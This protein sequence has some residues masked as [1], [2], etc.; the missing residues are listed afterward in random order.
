[1]LGHVAR[2]ECAHGLNIAVV[3][4]GSRVCGKPRIDLG[5]E[6]ACHP[7]RMTG[8]FARGE[9]GSEGYPAADLARDSAG[10][11]AEGALANDDRLRRVHQ[12]LG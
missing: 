6:D 12:D 8:A 10:D 1:M 11:E 4:V 9:S 2:R 5:I 7:S 3:D